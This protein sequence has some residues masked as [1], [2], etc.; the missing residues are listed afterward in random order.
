MANL[1]YV[2]KNRLIQ[3]ALDEGE[4]EKQ[5][6]IESAAVAQSMLLWY[7]ILLVVI[8]FS[9]RG[10]IST[11]AMVIMG[12]FWLSLCFAAIPPDE[13]KVWYNSVKMAG[14]EGE[15]T[16]LDMLKDLPDDYTIFN[17][18]EIPCQ[19][20]KRGFIELDF[21]VVS[22][23][24]IYVLEVKHSHGVFTGSAK[25]KT[26]YRDKE[27]SSG[28]IYSSI[29]PNP[30]KQLNWQIYQLNRFF[31]KHKIYAWIDG[32]VVFSH[33]DALLS[34]EDNSQI[35]GIHELMPKLS[36]LR[37]EPHSNHRKKQGKMIPVQ[38]II[39][40][41]AKLQSSQHHIQS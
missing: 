29:V 8:Y 37:Q 38:K 31:R 19:E 7:S 35:I 21:V 5:E 15:D 13:T 22:P 34:I 23:W 40:T 12:V 30:V 32:F 20:S 18:L 26:L 41:L 28:N 9:M 6:A 39:R 14:A 33:H 11:I 1:K 3:E 16:V 27:S 2:R 36:Q 4:A 10:D 17:Q 25:D 24:G